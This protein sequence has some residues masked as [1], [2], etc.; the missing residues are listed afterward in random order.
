MSHK[1]SLLQNHTKLLRVVICLGL[2]LAIA[3]TS[4]GLSAPR[5]A[6]QL[7]AYFSRW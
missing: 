4:F 2:L 3:P 5:E 1:Q 6:P 7:E